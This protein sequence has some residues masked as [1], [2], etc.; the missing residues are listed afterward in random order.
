MNGKPVHGPAP[1]AAPARELGTARRRVLAIVADAAAGLTVSQ[2]AQQF[3]GHPNASRAHLEALAADQLLTSASGQPIGR[4]RPARRYRITP[5]GRRALSGRSGS[6]YREL[7]HAFAAL[8]SASGDAAMAREVGRLWA[9]ELTRW[10]TDEESGA[11]PE[12]RLLR[13]LAALDFGPQRRPDGILLRT[14]P[15]VE[16]ARLNPG[17]I[18]GV[19]QGLVDAALQAWGD[20]AEARLQPF[21]S[22]EGCRLVRRPPGQQ[23]APGS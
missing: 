11:D 22:A 2:V 9:S 20:Q 3:G 15:F 5:A 18:C 23:S 1:V 17:V 10:D 6:D 14:C 4:G 16:E 12:E 13:L 8:L 19:H 21:S 7:T